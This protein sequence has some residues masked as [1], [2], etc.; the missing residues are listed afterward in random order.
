MRVRRLA[1]RLVAA[2]VVAVWAVAAGLV[3][4]AYRPG[5]PLDLL[6]GSTLAL[7]VII[8]V[9]GLVWPPVA[10]G[11]VLFAGTVWLGLGA[12]LCLIPAVAGLYQQLQALGSQ[13][14]LPSLEAAYPFLLALVATS[15]FSG[16]GIARRLRGPGA[17][18]R[19]RL[20][21]GF[22]VAVALTAVAATLFAGAAMANEFAVRDTPG[23]GSRFGPTTSSADPPACNGPLAAGAF[24]RLTMQL[25]ATV[26]RHPIGSVDLGGQRVGT[27][28][29]W[30]AYVATD[31]E[32]GLVGVVRKGDQAWQRDVGTGWRDTTPSQAAPM[33]GDIQI[34]GTALLATDRSTA[35]DRGV[36]VIERARA[37]RCRVAADGATFGEAFPEIKWLV[38]DIDLHRWRA[39]I[40]YWVFMDGQLGQVVGTASGEANGLVP[41]AIQAT[42]DVRLTATE[43]ERPL[44]VYPPIR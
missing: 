38:G 36:E 29:S 4:L 10:R 17:P 34:L 24:A 3:L 26:D 1:L 6:V 32:L 14:L 31:R 39:Q 18:R 12:L 19:R 22:A 30:T 35:E 7:P 5:G 13:T 8:A 21:D 37:R 2:A 20:L 42:I 23:V 15:L 25:S 28:F 9:T 33:A 44:V 43:R 27:D 11:D 40:D 41:N 16:L